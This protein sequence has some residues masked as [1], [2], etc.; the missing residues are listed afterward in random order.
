MSKELKPV[1]SQLLKH[2]GGNGFR[3]QQAILNSYDNRHD[4]EFWQF[5]DSQVA[6]N[7]KAGDAVLD[8][9]AAAGQ[10]VRDCANKYPSSQVTG[11]DAANYM[12]DFAIEQPDNGQLIFDDLNDPQ[13]SLNSNSY[14][15]IMANTVIHE[16]QQPVKMLKAAI[17]WLKP[18]GR[19]CLIEGV[20]QP[21]SKQLQKR[22]S[23]QQIWGD[24]SSIQELE[25][26]FRFHFEHNQYQAEDLEFLLKECG[27]TIISSELTHKKD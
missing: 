6:C 23:Q 13:A 12:M 3:A 11:I 24:K 16:L 15:M 25:G 22:Y 19:L 10:F 14:G 26:I 18:G 7:Y 8:M 17:K 9:G 2:H 4:A 27:F 5:W 21:L 1:Q 20:R